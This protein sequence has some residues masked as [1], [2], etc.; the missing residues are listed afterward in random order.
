MIQ[1]FKEAVKSSQ[2]ILD[3]RVLS[4]EAKTNCFWLLS[5]IALMILIQWGVTV[6]GFYFIWTQNFHLGVRM[7]GMAFL[8]WCAR[9]ELKK[10]F[11]NLQ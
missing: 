10:V 6:V 4:P 2:I 3:G 5:L 9:G 7:F 1:A 11:W 8:C